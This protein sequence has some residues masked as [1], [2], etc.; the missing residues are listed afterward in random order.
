LQRR[1]GVCND[2]RGV[3]SLD[4]ARLNVY[5]PGDFTVDSAAA[6]HHDDDDS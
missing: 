1:I 6:R 3:S 5:N 4:L 2:D